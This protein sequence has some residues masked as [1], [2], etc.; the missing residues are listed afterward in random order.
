M[1]RA[2]FFLL[3]LVL[4]PTAR[5][6]AQAYIQRGGCQGAAPS[7]TS[8]TPT[9][10]NL[11]VVFLADVFGPP[12][13]ATWT[14]TDSNST[15]YTAVTTVNSTVSGGTGTF[16]MS[17]ACGIATTPNATFTISVTESGGSGFT[18]VGWA[19]VSNTAHTACLDQ[20]TSNIVGDI[21]SGATAN[22]GSITP[23]VSD[24]FVVGWA[25][26][27]SGN[28]GANTGWTLQFGAGNSLSVGEG[29]YKVVSSTS[30]IAP[31]YL[32]TG[33]SGTA[34]HF[35][36]IT[37][38]FKNASAGAGRT[39]HQVMQSRAMSVSDPRVAW[40]NRRRFSAGEARP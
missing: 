23:T 14:V 21:S 20:F 34:H 22:T 35:F 10:G 17:Y 27:D 11:I 26:V 9:S 28:V 40:I 33:G 24:S 12:N 29:I 16:G 5:G 38:N 6:T 36:G 8:V 30:A 32:N 4:A 2:S 15:S 37:A 39:R 1:R 7:C 3:L 19:E 13:G 25:N 18:F 31:T